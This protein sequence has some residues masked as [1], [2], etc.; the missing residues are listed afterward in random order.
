MFAI[1]SIAKF[2]LNSTDKTAEKLVS[3]KKYKTN[4]NETVFASVAVAELTI[5]AIFLLLITL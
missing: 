1:N 3:K 5:I 4:R 2:T